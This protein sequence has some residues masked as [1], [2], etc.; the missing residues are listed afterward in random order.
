MEGHFY[1]VEITHEFNSKKGQ[2]AGFIS[3]SD[4]PKENK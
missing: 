3:Q 2:I 4:H 1:G